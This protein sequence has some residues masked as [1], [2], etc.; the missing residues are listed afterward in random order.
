M[1]EHVRD[2]FSN[3]Q[4]NT[5]QSTID[6]PPLF[7]EES[8]QGEKPYH[9]INKASSSHY[10]EQ[11]MMIENDEVEIKL[12][13][14]KILKDARRLGL[15]NDLVHLKIYDEIGGA[16]FIAKELVRVVVSE[17]FSIKN[18]DNDQR[19]RKICETL[20]PFCEQSNINLDEAIIDYTKELCNTAK[21]N[22]GAILVE[23]S[24][25]ARCCKE[26]SMKCEVALKVLRVAIL[27]KSKPKC[28][29]SLTID[30]LKWATSQELRSQL[31]EAS[32][33]LVI[34][35]IV[36]RYCGNKARDYFRV[37]NPRHS[38]RLLH[39]LCRFI[40]GST[41]LED[42]F[43]LCDAF[44]HLS[45]IDGCTLL[46]QR[47]VMAS[48]RT[49][50]EGISPNTVSCKTDNDRIDQ[51]TRLF[52]QAYTIDRKIAIAVGCRVLH[53]CSHIIAEC[54]SKISIGNHDGYDKFRETEEKDAIAASSSACAIITV[55][56]ENIFEVSNLA[57]NES[58]LKRSIA[59]SVTDSL[60]LLLQDYQ[61]IFELQT[62]FKI[63]LSLSD[64]SRPLS[65][66]DKIAMKLFTPISKLFDLKD[67][68]INSIEL[69]SALNYTR[70]GCSLIFG[71]SPY[72][73]ASNWCR[74]VGKFIC[75]AVRRYNINKCMQL[76][77]ESG[78][79]NEIGNGVSFQSVISVALS[80]CF[81]A[82]EQARTIEKHSSF[83]K[84]SELIL[85]SMKC[86]VCA[87][88][89]MQEHAVIHCPQKLLP[90]IVSL[91]NLTEIISQVLVRAD[92]G[93]GE[94]IDDYMKS[95]QSQWRLK[96]KPIESTFGLDLTKTES[97]DFSTANS[98]QPTWY[99]GDGI[100]L[101]PVEVL[102][103]CTDYCKDILSLSSRFNYGSNLDV[104]SGIYEF[105]GSRGA[106]SISLRMLA[107]ATTITMSTAN[108]Q[109]SHHQA[110][111]DHSKK[112]LH[113]C[114]KLSE[115]SLGGSGNGILSGFIDSQ[116]SVSYLLSL[117]I[118]VAF[119][120]SIRHRDLY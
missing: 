107:Y 119:K 31:E 29:S 82:S 30:A 71:E 53:F 51:C 105:L 110:L 11:T 17:Q 79:L 106:Y 76:I 3:D 9:L 25:L 93:T 44:M 37:E 100:L 35:D 83:E 2:G 40:N 45:K 91:S 97:N 112:M 12:L 120:V 46:F 56:K 109:Y 14:A 89:L 86:V 95:L 21:D 92:C 41:I 43:S 115:R 7:D 34:D 10:N 1:N 98:L 77:E 85:T 15:S 74:I 101:P 102:I 99:I 24:T 104:V 39:Q 108:T 5:T 90:S 81:K 67:S 4:D 111:H 6:F 60:P 32:R 87:S 18:I 64:L 20:E 68:K 114:Q 36:R 8:V 70:R 58:Y 113:I 84:N 48:S 96:R 38:V 69:K 72:E 63:F 50:S 26:P 103:Y 22:P 75:T 118:K 54:S 13:H 78:L 61:R 47:I 88:S 57:T 55:M 19:Q 42:I 62:K 59:K 28:L 65:H 116:L 94:I 80:L 49:H 117:P 73:N 66:H 33:L 52:R 23:A 16:N 27:Y